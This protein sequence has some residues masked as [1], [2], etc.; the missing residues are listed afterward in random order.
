[1]VINKVVQNDKTII[2]RRQH[3]QHIISNLLNL[4]FTCMADNL[5]NL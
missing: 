3:N 4:D 1:M 2:V 5:A